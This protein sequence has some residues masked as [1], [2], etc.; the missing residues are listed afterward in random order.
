VIAKGLVVSGAVGVTV[1]LLFLLGVFDGGT[2]YASGM[3]AGNLDGGSETGVQVPL[4]RGGSEMIGLEVVKN[5]GKS[6]ILIESIEPQ[7]TS[8]ELHAT[9]G[10]ILRVRR[11]AH[12]EQPPLWWHGWPPKGVP[13]SG[14]KTHP[15]DWRVPHP[16][17]L[18]LPTK[19]D[20]PPGAE[21]QLVYGIFLHADPSPKIRITAVRITFVQSGR[22]YVWTLPE[23]VRVDYHSRS[24]G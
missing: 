5:V 2:V 9:R 20:V 6:P 21:A 17:Y 18:S 11:R 24:H 15:N 10:R 13:F 14:S 12:F 22:T 4:R 7:S 23:E 19:G 8:P 3:R 16:D 1:L